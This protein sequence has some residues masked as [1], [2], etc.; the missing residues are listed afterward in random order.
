MKVSGKKMNRKIDIII[1]IISAILIVLFG[2][3]ILSVTIGNEYNFPDFYDLTSEQYN[4]LMN[5]A[6]ASDDNGEYSPLE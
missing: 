5:Y 3:T 4:E 1:V 6:L 2:L